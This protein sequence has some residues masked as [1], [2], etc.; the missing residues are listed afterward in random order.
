MRT[1]SL[2]RIISVFWFSSHNEIA[3]GTLFRAD[4]VRSTDTRTRKDLVV[5]GENCAADVTDVK[6]LDYLRIQHRFGGPNQL[7]VSSQHRR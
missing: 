5:H 7:L 3:H 6:I 1:L 4:A 2:P